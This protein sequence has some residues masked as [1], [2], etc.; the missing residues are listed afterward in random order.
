MILISGPCVI[1]NKQILNDI[2]ENIIKHI[3]DHNEIDFYFKA[4]CIKDNRTNNNNFRGVG[5]E[6]G[7]RYLLDIKQQYGVKITTDFHTADQV[8]EYAKY[9]DLIQIPAFLAMQSSLLDEVAK[10]NIPINIKKPQFLNP[11]NIKN[12]VNKIKDQN[13]NAIVYATD[14]GT[15]FG[16]DEVIF[17]PRH[18]P[19][20][21]ETGVCDKIIVDI[22]HPQNHSKMYNRDYAYSLG[23]ASIAAGADGLF[24][25][26]HID[27]SKALCDGD[28]Q[29]TIP[30]FV[31]YIN[32]FIELD[33][34]IKC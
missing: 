25:E 21:K 30:D 26:T 11:H 3:I 28:S 7:I 17:D 32:K 34:I 19:A 1:E 12:P 20:M 5:F 31:N 2:A 8:K 18:I 13:K 23:M 33:K 22:T 16:Y 29:L 24:M 6:K 15:K 9:V 10:F 14:R 4:S 27:P